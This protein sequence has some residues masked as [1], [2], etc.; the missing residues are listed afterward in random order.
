MQLPQHRPWPSTEIGRGAPGRSPVYVAV[1]GGD[2]TL[3][4][5]RGIMVIK[6]E[7]ALIGAV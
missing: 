2:V 7:R 5:G 3:R 6:E 4:Q 1:G